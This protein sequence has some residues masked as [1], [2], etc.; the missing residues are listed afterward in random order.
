MNTFYISEISGSSIKLNIEESKHC[1]KV[2]RLRKGDH[3][4]L[5]NGRGSMF[6]AVIQIPDSKSCVLEI[7]KEEKHRIGRSYNL[8]IALAPTKNID[9]YEWFIEKSTEIGID[10]IIPLICQHS[11]RKDIKVERI[12][13]ILISAMKQSGQMFLPELTYPISFKELISKPFDGDKLI[14]HCDN[15]DK[16][17]LKD[18]VTPGKDV[19]I[20]IGPEGD[21]DG[22]EIKLAL[23]NGFIPVSLGESRLRTETA[24]IVA[25]HTVLLVNK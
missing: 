4:L 17:D 6:E 21:F 1:I 7:L 22:E 9:R 19:L 18:S 11:E 14:A 13:K 16:K 2:L 3:V 24:G 5:M 12:E 8:T 25:C 20:L 23:K 10:R 15:G